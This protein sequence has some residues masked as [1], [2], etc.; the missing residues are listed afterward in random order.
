MTSAATNTG[1]RPG[2]QD[3]VFLLRPDGAIEQAT[4]IALP[5]CHWVGDFTVPGVFQPQLCGADG[6]GHQ[7]ND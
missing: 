5:N 7:R 1:C 6:H 2:K 3:D 4:P